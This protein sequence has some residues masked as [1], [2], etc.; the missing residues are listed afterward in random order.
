M[1]P[2]WKA[3]PASSLKMRL[4]ISCISATGKDSTAGLPAAREMTFGSE[5]LRISRIAEGFRLLMRSANW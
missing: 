4:A 1:M 3:T 2:Y 5:F